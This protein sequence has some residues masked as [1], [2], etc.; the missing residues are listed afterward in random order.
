MTEELLYKEVKPYG[1]LFVQGREYFVLAPMP[2]PEDSWQAQDQQVWPA[3]PRE[4][5]GWNKD[6]TYELFPPD[7]LL[8]VFAPQITV[9]LSDHMKRIWVWS[10]D[11]IETDQ[12]E[13]ET[14]A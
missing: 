13:D 7:V 6:K 5:L 1:K 3:V 2:L 10:G 9:E 8:V 14:D 4:S 11:R 12:F